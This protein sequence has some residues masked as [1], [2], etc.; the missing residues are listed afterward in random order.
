MADHK[1]IAKNTIALY[2]RMGL[3]MIIS[4]YT[5]RIVLDKLGIED[6]GIYNLV[7]GVVGMLTFLNTAM[8]GA[9]SRFITYEIGRGNKQ[10]IKETFGSAVIIHYIIAAVI[11]IL[12]ET[13]GLWFV[14]SKLVI[15]EESILAANIVFQFSILSTCLSIIQTPY[16]ADIVSHEKFTLYAYV[17]ILNVFLKLLVVYLLVIVPTNKL[18]LY[19]VLNFIVLII[20]FTIYRTY[21]LRK[22]EETRGKPQWNKK[23]ATPMLQFSG[24]DLFGNLSVAINFQGF[25]IAMNMIYGAAINAAYGIA[26]TVQGTLKGLAMNII[27]ASRPQIIK[28]YA[29]GNLNEMIIL[30]KNASNLSIVMYLMIAVPL[31]FNAQAVLGVWL[32]E[33]PPHSAAM[34][35]IILI[36][37]IFSILNQ[38]LNIAVHATGKIRSLS[39]YPGIIYFLS[40]FVCY[41][42]MK[43]GVPV[44]TAFGM[45]IVTY[46]T[47]FVICL[48]IVK[49]LIPTLQIKLLVRDYLPIIPFLVTLVSILSLCNSDSIYLKFVVDLIISVNGLGLYYLLF[50][51]DKRQRITLFNKIRVKLSIKKEL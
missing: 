2:L 4:L 46:A 8:A 16:N 23:T 15:P 43:V 21:C 22:F 36:S 17:E 20:V 11:F 38:I 34:L 19:S 28:S 44:D 39:I 47:C 31:Y 3:T 50:C 49:C 25:G 45:I 33:A 41:F 40:P 14:N 6:Y 30:M 35:K 51:L 27:S 26:N 12:A 10:C 48:I 5:S 9:S 32:V 13:I 29:S 18:I 24:W 37:G 42:I 7:G 1:L